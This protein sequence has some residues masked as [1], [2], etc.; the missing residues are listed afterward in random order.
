MT[1]EPRGIV[2][3]YDPSEDRL[4]L[5]ISHQSPQLVQTLFAK[6]LGMPENRIRNSHNRCWRGFWRKLHVYA[7]EMATV[8]A[9]RVLGR[10]VK[11]IAS[12]PEAFQS[13]AQAREFDVSAAIH[14]AADGALIGMTG[15]FENPIGAYSIYPRSSVGDAIQAATQLGARIS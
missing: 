14:L 7:D 12:G 3:S 4:E 2:A 10:P 6:L 8:L 15:E 9:S 5:W 13:D 11:Y 1:L